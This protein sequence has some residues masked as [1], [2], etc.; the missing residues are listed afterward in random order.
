[1]I[2]S[3]AWTLALPVYCL[4]FASA[5]CSADFDE[6]LYGRMLEDCQFVLQYE[7]QF[8]VVSE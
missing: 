2:V 3:F 1:M 7:C 4:T 8:H 5:N 6:M